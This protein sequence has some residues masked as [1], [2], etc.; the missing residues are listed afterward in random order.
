MMGRGPLIVDVLLS[1]LVL[2]SSVSSRRDNFCGGPVWRASTELVRTRM[3]FTPRNVR[4]VD[5]VGR[6][7]RARLWS[8]QYRSRSLVANRFAVPDIEL[9]ARAGVAN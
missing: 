1:K 9:Y 6:S 4:T 3:V 8:V 2:I 5:A 7:E